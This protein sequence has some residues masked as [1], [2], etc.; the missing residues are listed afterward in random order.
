MDN[1]NSSLFT[2][3]WLPLIIILI[4]VVLLFVIFYHLLKKNKENKLK[5]TDKKEDMKN[6]FDDFDNYYFH[7]G[8]NNNKSYFIENEND[9]IIYEIRYDDEKDNEYLFYDN[10]SHIKKIHHVSSLFKE[11]QDTNILGLN[12]SYSF[13][14]DDID[15]YQ[16][17]LSFGYQIEENMTFYG[18]TYDILFNN[19]IIGKISA[20]NMI[21][22]FNTTDNNNYKAPKACYLIQVGANDLYNFIDICFILSLTDI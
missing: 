21:H 7:F 2:N 5:I 22:P 10:V 12:L 16:Y 8:G 19:K 15:C 4:V 14:L 9:E 1:N 18:K 6:D 3:M 20:T 13:K 11:E 17:L